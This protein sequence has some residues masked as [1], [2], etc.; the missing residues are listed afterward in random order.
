MPLLLQLPPVCSHRQEDDKYCTACHI[1]SHWAWQEAAVKFNL[2]TPMRFANDVP[3]TRLLNIVRV[4]KPT[5]AEL[6]AVFDWGTC[7]VGMTE[8]RVTVLWERQT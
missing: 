2:K 4:R 8:V 3:F 7:L 6:D 5:Q 1:S